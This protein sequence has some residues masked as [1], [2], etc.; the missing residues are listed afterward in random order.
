M[1]ASTVAPACAVCKSP[2][3]PEDRF[4]TQC[5]QTT[6]RIYWYSSPDNQPREGA[7]AIPEGGV[8]YLVAQNTGNDVARVAVDPARLRGLRLVGSFEAWVERR[9]SVAFGLQHIEGEPVGGVVTMMSEDG[10]R[11]RPSAR[12]PQAHWW[13]PRGMRQQQYRA[14]TI[15]RIVNDRWVVGAPNVLFPPGVRR[16][17]MRIWNDSERVRTFDTD[18]PAGYQVIHQITDVDK[19]APELPANS[20]VELIVEAISER[21]IK[22]SDSNWLIGPEEERVGL[23]RLPASPDEAGPDIV[24]SIDFGTRN[25]GV[26]VRWRH[27]LV[28]GKPKGLVE[29]IGDRD[30][31]PRFPTEM[32][33]HRTGR[34]FQWGSEVPRGMLPADVIRIS[35][36]KTYLRVGA[37]PYVKENP[38]WTNS[39]LL[40]RYFEQLFVRIDEYFKAVDPALFR[41]NLNIRYDITRPV[42][43]ANED[44]AQGK[45]YEA[46]LLKALERCGIVREQILFVYE[47]VAA[48]YGIARR[49]VGELLA[50]GE[51]ALIAVI[52][53]GGGTT[54]VAVAQVS[55]RDGR[56]ALKIK[57]AYA[58]HLDAGN[59][60]LASVVRFGATDR[61][62]LGGDVLD[63]ALTHKLLTSAAELLETEG[64]PVPQCV[65][66]S[67]VPLEAHERR[68]REAELVLSCRTMKE[69]F[70]Y[71]STHHLTPPAGQQIRPHEHCIFA[72]RPEYEGIYLEQSLFGDHLIT[73]ILKAPVED[74]LERMESD[75]FKEGGIR[76]SQVRQVFYVGGTNIEFYF[77]QQLHNAFPNTPSLQAEGQEGVQE[78]I[79]ERLNAVVEGAVWCD[80]L[81]FA[82]S[83][84]DLKLTLDGSER[85]LIMKGDPLPPEISS[86]LRPFLVRLEPLQELE[87]TLTA[88]NPAPGEH[89]AVARGHYRNLSEN[90]EEGTLQV[91][92]SREKGVVANLIVNGKSYD[93]WRFELV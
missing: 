85:A 86:P 8:F 9:Q 78:R 80:E 66:V 36:L 63:Y 55:L 22:D 3:K 43:D 29:A 14:Q 57:G 27:E 44:D 7:S 56:L 26:R 65:D 71:I 77:R 37:E 53:A 87:A 24:L 40:E 61:L 79:A 47:P 21:A 60:A 76:P 70:A 42:L 1:P 83:P 10:P 16:Q 58:L 6:A 11:P 18:I 88:T 62:E 2:L 38:Q 81:M 45:Q 32:A 90:V 52:D 28:V 4:C 12:E 92:I 64:R 15:V 19:K 68:R 82:A 51:G 73:P 46:L 33:M 34:S 30:G 69:A 54:D 35:N 84:L 59:P 39:Y 89:V 25:T 49:H 74:L 5:G 31:N 50:L 20:S 91:R 23:H 93:Q 41:Q 48:A 67:A 17:Y 13:E 72:N 75:S